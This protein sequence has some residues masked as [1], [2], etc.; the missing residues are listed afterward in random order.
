MTRFTVAFLL[1]LTLMVSAGGRILAQEVPVEGGA[2]EQLGAMAIDLYTTGWT[3]TEG[4]FTY[5]KDEATRR[6]LISVKPGQLDHTYFVSTTLS[7]GTGDEFFAAPMMWNQSAFE[8]RREGQFIEFV[9]PNYQITTVMGEPMARAVEA[10]ISDFIFGKAPVEAEDEDDGEVAIELSGFLLGS[11][12]IEAAALYYGLQ[13]TID[14]ELSYVDRIKGFPKNDEIDTRVVLYGAGGP[15]GGGI[16]EGQELGL[17]FSLAEP[18]DP[19]YMPRYADDRVGNFVDLAMNYSVATDK[20]ETRYVRYVQRWRLEKAEPEAEMSEPVQPI[21]FWLEN[22]IPYEYRDAIRE[23]VLVWNAAFERI[24]YR[25]AIVA[26][27]M[28]DDADWDPADSRYNTIRY[29]VSPPSTYAIGPSRTDPRTGEIYDADVGISAD[30]FR[31]AYREY[32]LSIAPVRDAVEAVF[33]PGWPNL[34]GHQVRWDENTQKKLEG[35]LRG[36]GGRG[37]RDGFATIH[38]F[39]GSRAA[40]ILGARDMLEPG[41]PEEEQFIHDY[42]V[43]LVCHEVGHVLGLTHN[44]G[45]SAGTSFWKLN[46]TYWTRQHGLS[47][48][49]MDYTAANIAPEGELQGEYYQTSLG[50]YDYWAIEYAYKRIQADAPEAELEELGNVASRA[51][52]YRYGADED[53]YGWTRNPD[54]D[55]YMWDLSDDPVRF[56]GSRLTVSSQLMDRILEHW[57]EPGTR[58]SEI[59]NAFIYA[60]WDYVLAANAVPRLIGGV[61]V[62][63]D[64]VGDPGGHPSLV[65]VK[66]EDQRRALAFLTNRIWSPDAYSFDPTLLNMLGRDRSEVFDWMSL[67][68]GTADFDTHAWVNMAQETP[69]YWLYDPMVLERIVNNETRM[70]PGEDAFTLLQLFDGVRSSIWAE[71]DAGMSINGFRRDLQ[72]AHLEM[73]SGI[74]LNPANGTP[75]D[76]ITLARRDLAILKS[77]IF[78]LLNGPGAAN[79]DTMS[80]A[81]LEEC[82]SR[83]NLTLT[84]PM[85][86]GPE[87]IAFSLSF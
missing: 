57:S 4:L 54:P 58:P 21:V 63:R 30:M 86:R 24:G 9:K 59:R 65:P 36:F 20:T 1:M 47:Q 25:N 28:P 74:V 7:R 81:H 16:T 14:Y 8:F 12:G 22:T 73:I 17:H 78:G 39:E 64:R 87:S 43:S 56:H 84:A 18:P 5:Y 35:Q 48:S 3:K 60:L 55:V 53:V 68:T 26:K 29:F 67:Y 15:F 61:R 52:Q 42:I 31:Y 41:S 33:P 10:G 40:T 75:E 38:A 46:Q 11:T 49:I 76:A 27:Q 23:G 72:R 32:D 45:G 80:R 70:P 85:R 77:R 62:Y 50:D 34:D 2:P 79:L 13:F 6:V 82:L 69:L 71:V 19:G 44:F 51:P 66:A 37:M 83:I